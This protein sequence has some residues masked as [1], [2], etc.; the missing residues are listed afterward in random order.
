MQLG[1]SCCSSEQALTSGLRSPGNKPPSRPLIKQHIPREGST[2][3]SSRILMATV[4]AIALAVPA[5]AQ[6]Q[7]KPLETEQEPTQQPEQAEE[8]LQEESGDSA[9]AA[10]QG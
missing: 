9:D 7:A 5:A 1:Q 10:A 6:E 3:M 8:T 2:A 4:A